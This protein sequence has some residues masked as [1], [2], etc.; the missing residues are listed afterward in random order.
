MHVLFFET[1]VVGI[2]SSSRE[3]KKKPEGRAT[4]SNKIRVAKGQNFPPMSQAV[5]KVQTDSIGLYLLKKTSRTVVTINLRM[6]NEF[7]DVIPA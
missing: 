4:P 2:I 5:V 3:G 7:R 6:A 1:P